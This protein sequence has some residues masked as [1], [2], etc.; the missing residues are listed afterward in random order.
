MH[1]AAIFQRGEQ[2]ARPTYRWTNLQG[3]SN[4]VLARFIDRVLGDFDLVCFAVAAAVVLHGGH[5]AFL[6]VLTSYCCSLV[7]QHDS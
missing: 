2:Q 3:N 5:C 7:R 1:D 4:L 6:R